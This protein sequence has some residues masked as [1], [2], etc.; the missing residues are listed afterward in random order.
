MQE[1][2]VVLIMVVFVV[3]NVATGHLFLLNV[4]LTI[5][6]A[7]SRS[8]KIILAKIL[9]KFRMIIEIIVLLGSHLLGLL[10]LDLLF[11]HLLKENKNL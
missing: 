11:I 1:A 7:L 8:I 4:R 5:L 6:N 10:L 9:L 3:V 2:V